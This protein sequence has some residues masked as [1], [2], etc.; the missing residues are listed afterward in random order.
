MD[1]FPD[2]SVDIW[3][4]YAAKSQD[5]DG[6]GIGRVLLTTRGVKIE[7]AIETDFS[8]SNNK[9]CRHPNM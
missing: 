7:Q 1:V 9:A 4:M 2:L 6:S 3:V 5:K 8:V